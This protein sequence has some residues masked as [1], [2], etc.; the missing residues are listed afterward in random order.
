[1]F[2]LTLLIYLLSSSSVEGQ[3]FL[4]KAC[5]TGGFSNI[6]GECR[7]LSDCPSALSNFRSGIT[8]TVCYMEVKFGKITQK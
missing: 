8:P 4:G 7:Q 1:M 6:P 5:T 3:L 2:S